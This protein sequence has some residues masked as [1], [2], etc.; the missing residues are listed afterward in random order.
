MTKTTKID[1]YETV[2]N[3]MIALLEKGV[4]PWRSPWSKY[5]LARNYATGHVY[6]G[7]NAFL[8]NL[9]EH[10]IPY[11]MSFKQIKAKSGKI[12]KGAK[13]EMV[14]FYK[15]YYKDEQGQTISP[16]QYSALCE[17][18]GEP[19]RISF[20]KYYPVFNIQDVEGIE[21]EIPE[22]ELKEH[23]RIER[24]EAVKNNMPNPP[25]FV[26]QD[27]NRA[28]YAPM[29]DKLNMPDIAQFDTPEEYYSTLFHELTHS[30]GHASRLARK[31]ITELT[32]SDRK[33][34]SKEE[35]IAEMGASFLAAHT[36][37]NTDDLTENSA[38]YLEGWLK[39][40][41]SDKKLIFKAAAKAQKAVDYIL[42]VKRV[43]KD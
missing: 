25:E 21:I 11:F 13:S 32:T 1:L 17:M 36:G 24:C 8:M 33:Q 31:G 19:Q 22:V 2:T 6:S 42:N 16:D 10:P 29:S 41:K 3:K 5:G 15:T 37:I 35:L 14:F 38:A 23:E 20:L 18:G 43:Y 27:A 4:A 9:T 30:T 26:F 12:K 28:Y 34:Y 40:L 7:I 39:I